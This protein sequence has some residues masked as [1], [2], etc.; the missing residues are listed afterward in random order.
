M[1]GIINDYRHY[2]MVA[3]NIVDICNIEKVY[4]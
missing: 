2:I 3:N 4:E 1:L